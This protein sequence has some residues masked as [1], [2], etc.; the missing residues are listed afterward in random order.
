MKKYYFIIA[1]VLI[2][3]FL[4]GCGNGSAEQIDEQASGF[5]LDTDQATSA[6]SE[7]EQSGSEKPEPEKILIYE[8]DG[9]KAYYLDYIIEQPYPYGPEVRLYFENNKDIDVSLYSQDFSVN[10]IMLAA[11]LSVDVPARGAAPGYIYIHDTD[12]DSHGITAFNKIEFV[13]GILN[14]KEHYHL[15]SEPILID[16]D[17]L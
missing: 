4:T 10:G 5:G 1:I 16:T 2:C 15:V 14:A 12:F 17:N 7:S 6:H 9:V 11:N 3:S 8:A 13:L